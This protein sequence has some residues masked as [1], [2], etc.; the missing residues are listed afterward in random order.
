MI[1]SHFNKSFFFYLNT[2]VCTYKI[3]YYIEIKICKC[4]W[5]TYFDFS[6][7]KKFVCL[8]CFVVKYNI[9]YP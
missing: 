5:C 7:L 4:D 2:C 9:Y 6:T 3:K 8:F 1:I